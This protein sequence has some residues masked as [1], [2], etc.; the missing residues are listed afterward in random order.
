MGPMKN[1]KRVEEALLAIAVH[2]N[3]CAACIESLFA[4]D[5]MADPVCAEYRRLKAAAKVLAGR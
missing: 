2:M 5:S 1:K 4:G 3:Q